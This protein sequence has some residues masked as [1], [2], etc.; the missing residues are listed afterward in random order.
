MKL[1]TLLA[2]VLSFVLGAC[3]TTS[4]RAEEP[5]LLVHDVY[6]TLRDDTPA[7]RAALANACRSLAQLDVVLRLAVGERVLELNRP[8]NDQAFGVAL[9][10]IFRDAAA[11]AAY[12]SSPA[13]QALLATWTPKFASVRVFDSW[14]R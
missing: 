7:E 14:S 10:V 6:F 8:V 4:A 2:L 9:H 12:Q 5:R 13:H 3:H 11:Q 1:K